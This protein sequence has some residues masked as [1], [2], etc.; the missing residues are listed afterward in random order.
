MK[1]RDLSIIIL[2]HNTRDWVLNALRCVYENFPSETKTEVIVVDNA[3]S[4]DSVKAIQTEFPKTS[5]I[6]SSK[7]GGFAHGNNLAITQS[8]SRYIMLLNSDAEFT[9]N[10]SIDRMI[11]YMDQ[12]PHVAVMTPKLV[13]PD[14]A[15]DLASHRGEPDPWSAFTYFS[16]LER[17][18]PESKTFGGYHQTWQNFEETHEIAACSGAAMIVRMTAVQKVGV[19]DERFFMYAEDLDWCKRFRDAGYSIVFFPDSQVV[20]HKYKSGIGKTQSNSKTKE[21]FFETMK[22]YYEK[23]YDHRSKVE[24]ALTFF[25]IDVMKR[26]KK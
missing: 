4:D 5:L 20:H 12:H 17:V 11:D 16:K 8:D 15:I 10:T 2:N 25:M 6:L 13:L 23:H 9:S 21:Y 3:S 19:L 26:F 22:Q 1:N 14:G 24:K 18:F 7:N